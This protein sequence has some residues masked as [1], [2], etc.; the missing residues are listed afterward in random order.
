MV[1]MVFALCH[2]YDLIDRLQLDREV[3]FRFVFG[4][5]EGYKAQNPYHNATHGSYRWWGGEV[6]VSDSA[7]HH[8]LG[9][10]SV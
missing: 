3:L 2:K 6:L 1:Y 8:Y 5:E 9:V 10:W 7:R 4:I